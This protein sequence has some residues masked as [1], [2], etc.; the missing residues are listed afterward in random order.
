VTRV[1]YFEQS[2]SKTTTMTSLSVSQWQWRPQTRAVKRSK[3]CRRT[4]E[5]CPST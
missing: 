5:W 4:S 1:V 2:M 3:Y